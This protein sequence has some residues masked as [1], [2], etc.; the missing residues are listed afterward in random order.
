MM[1]NKVGLS[2][3]LVSAVLLLGGCF[4][5]VVIPQ[6]PLMSDSKKIE[7]LNSKYSKTSFDGSVK[8]CIVK[9]D[10]D[11]M[12]KERDIII[13]EL[14]L[15]VDYN[16]QSYEG[17]LIAGKAKSNFGFGMASTILSLG[18]AVSTVTDTKT[19]ISSIAS[20]T[21]STRTEI[22]KNF[23]YEQTAQALIVKMKALRATKK[24]SLIKGMAIPYIDY[25]MEQ[26]L[27]DILEY[28]R[29]GT[30]ANAVQSIYEDAAHQNRSAE[31]ANMEAQD[32][33]RKTELKAAGFLEK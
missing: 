16:Y 23:Y 25:T 6:N 19:I 3:L 13:N 28:Y 8:E 29:A 26:G 27:V 31:Q 5:V 1:L 24:L 11:C 2:V 15:L 33:V 7:E 18:S 14:I 32:K 4:G 9:K 22:D 10:K 21:S 12:K 30:L 17:S 20:L